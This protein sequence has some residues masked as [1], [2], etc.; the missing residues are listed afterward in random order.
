MMNHF[1]WMTIDGKSSKDF[2]MYISGGGTYSSPEK[3]YEEVEIPGKNGVLFLYDDNYKN[4]DVKYDAWIAEIDGQR[5]VDTK[6]RALRSFL[7]SRNGYVRIEDT[8]HPDEFRFGAYNDSIDPSMDP[9][10]SIA[11]FEI[12]F[13][14]KPQ[15]Y[16]KRFYDIPIE[17]TSSGTIFNNETYFNAKPLIRVYGTGSFSVG[18]VTVTI[19]SANSYTDFDCEL[20]E[21]FKDTLA[22]NCNGNITLTNA[23]FPYLPSGE[24]TIT[25]SGPSKIVLYPRLFNL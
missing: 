12:N 10:L 19:N 15:R 5:N 13:T 14:C 18:G 1:H 22:T 8:Y 7:M 17:I 4:V 3:S 25:F 2:D 11:S 21:A 16:L 20:Q 23:K 6:F 9:S 24:S